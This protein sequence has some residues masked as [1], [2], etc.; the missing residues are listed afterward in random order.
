[1][2][3]FTCTHCGQIL[4]FENA[5]C[6]RCGTRLGFLP[7]QLLL[8]PVAPRHDGHLVADLDDSGLWQTCRNAGLIDCNWL[9]PAGTGE[10]FCQACALNRT[11]P[12]LDVAGNLAR[13]SEIESAKR[14]LVYALIRLGLPIRRPAGETEAGLAFDFVADTPDKPVLTGHEDGLVTVNIAE[15]DSPERERRR[16]E[17]AEPYRTLL[18]HLRH[19]VGHYYWDVLVR[20][21]GRLDETR[22][23]FGDESVDY[24]EALESHYAS[25]PPPDWQQT[26]V[27]AYATAH[28]WED[29][30]ETW[31]HYLHMISTL[32]TARSFGI[33]VDPSV[34]SEPESEA[35]FERDPYKA[36]DFEALVED[37]LPLTV[38][39]N[40]LNRSMGQP[41]L[42]PFVLPPLVITKLGF[43]HALVHGHV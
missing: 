43:I 17:M 11:I 40:S 42:Y 15:A 33:I 16:V 8:S 18:G 29:F 39:L 10:E 21:G 5:T 32:D 3:V 36:A 9:V 27:S 22:A 26:H 38:A 20:E 4:H 34:S 7:D 35:H 24:A 37:W 25:G 30:A 1:M 2:K 28:A 23:V 13:W 41:D 19:E 6:L 31:A 14:R 12:N